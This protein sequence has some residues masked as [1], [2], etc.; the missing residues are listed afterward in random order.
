MSPQPRRVAP[1][2]PAPA[3][4]HIELTGGDLRLRPPRIEE[5]DLYAAWWADPEVQW[6]F[7]SEA[8]TADDIRAAFPEMEAE[9]RDIGHWI[10]FVLE[11]SGRPVG[12]LWLSRW[13]LDAA[14][15]E[16]NILLG[17]AADRSRGLARRAIRLLAA[18][19]F[20]VMG[21]KRILLVPRDDH[22][23]AIRCYRAAGAVL[24]EIRPE[25]VTWRG[26]T[27]CFRELILLPDRL[28][29][30]PAS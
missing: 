13:D 4:A 9:A 23:P 15:C 19:A 28:A 24:G 30:P 22:L 7:C 29:P 21:L 16:M 17:S 18:W 1:A 25:V 3:P 5:A 26:E 20:P 27:V 12:Y 10:E 6:G 2:A 8:R 11:E 14:E